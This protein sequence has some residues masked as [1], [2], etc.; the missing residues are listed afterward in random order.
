MKAT[1]LYEFM[2]YGAPELIEARRRHMSRALAVTCAAAIVL[3]VAIMGVLPLVRFAPPARERVISI[4]PF[5]VTP[6]PV[7]PRPPAPAP[8]A[9]HPSAPV[10]KY[11]APVPVPD[12]AAPP[13]PQP[14]A[15]PGVKGDEKSDGTDVLPAP[16]TPNGD[17][18]PGPRDPVYVEQLPSPLKQAKP[19]YP[20]IAIEAG[21]GG[22]VMV[23]A[24]IGK[25]GHVLDA[26]VEEKYSVPMLNEA[27]LTAARQWIFTPGMAGERPVVC[28]V[29]IPFHFKLH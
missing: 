8:V 29:T 22:L 17:A 5:E 21:V 9:T 1:P 19:L 4:D 7:V 27:A 24:M 23:R 25:D 28:W 20:E 12:A 11:A 14:A 15:L 3:C 16:G 26:L 2:P 18:L 6:P 13:A 10:A